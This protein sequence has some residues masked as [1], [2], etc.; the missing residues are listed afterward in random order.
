MS[1]GVIWPQLWEAWRR[2]QL[3]ANEEACGDLPRPGREQR[4]PRLREGGGGQSQ[5]QGMEA[6]G[7][8]FHPQRCKK[9]QKEPVAR[10]PSPRCTHV[11]RHGSRAG[12][13]AASVGAHQQVGQEEG[14]QPPT[15]L[16]DSVPKERAG[17]AR[18]PGSTG[19]SRG[20]Q[21]VAW[22]ASGAHGALTQRAPP[23]AGQ[24]PTP[25]HRAGVLP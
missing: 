13:G 8:F 16:P 1:T 14:R 23:K 6:S 20:L 3:A 5:G 19:L 22:G 17:R 18:A 25:Q 24:P 11:R 4:G 7:G 9:R 10:R 2:Q 12:P 15:R 21:A